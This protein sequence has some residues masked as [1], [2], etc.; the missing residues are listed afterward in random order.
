MP[1]QQQGSAKRK[2]DDVSNSL[3]P[4]TEVKAVTKNS[5]AT[6]YPAGKFYAQV[7]DFLHNMLCTDNDV[8]LGSFYEPH[9]L[10][11][12]G[13]AYFAH[14][15]AK[16][17]QPDVRDIHNKLVAPWRFYDVLRPGTVILAL[18]SLHVFFITDA[19]GHNRKVCSIQAKSS[20][21]TFDTRR[22][23]RSFSLRHIVSVCLPNLW[24]QWRD[25]NDLS[26][27]EPLPIPQVP[28]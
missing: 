24:K 14:V 20:N 22:L 2:L 12:Y 6:G 8:K 28:T 18:V 21:L 11:D 13:G 17:T 19:G 1:K 7:I 27:R 5:G 15:H 10:E 23:L 4:N 16:L 26:Y 25:A 9:L 3:S